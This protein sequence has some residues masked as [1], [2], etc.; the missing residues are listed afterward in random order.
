M[1][2]VLNK[3]DLNVEL[4]RAGE[5]G[6]EELLL[7]ARSTTVIK[8]KVPRD[9]KQVELSYVVNNMLIAPEKGLPVKIVAVLQ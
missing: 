6:P 3:C 8:A 9:T 5:V 4:H 7:M 2:E 1:L